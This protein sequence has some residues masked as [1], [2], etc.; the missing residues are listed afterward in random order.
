MLDKD[1]EVLTFV[2]LHHLGQLQFIGHIACFHNITPEGLSAYP[3]LPP[4]GIHGYMKEP[5]NSIQT[6]IEGFQVL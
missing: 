1:V 5:A 6:S 3:W 4:V 2:N